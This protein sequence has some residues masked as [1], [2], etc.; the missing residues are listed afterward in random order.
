MEG[1][2]NF[3][4][5][6]KILE[7]QGFEAEHR[8]LVE[9]FGC[10]ETYWKTSIVENL[11]IP[12]DVPKTS[13]IDDIKDIADDIE[14]I[15]NTSIIEEGEILELSE[16]HAI[17]SNQDLEENGIEVKPEKVSTKKNEKTEPIEKEASLNSGERLKDG[18][19]EEPPSIRDFSLKNGDLEEPSSIQD[20]FSLGVEGE[21][22]LKKNS[23]SDC[24]YCDFKLTGKEKRGT[25]QNLS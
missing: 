6:L 9:L 22:S 18:D 7:N 16:D 14:D 19:L 15:A 20:L 21:T 11:Y 13:L 17:F 5:C 4:A 10:I 24:R 23:S 1:V 3:A 8:L 12:K 2:N 25:A